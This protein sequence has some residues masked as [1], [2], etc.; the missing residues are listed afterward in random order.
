MGRRLPTLR[1][2]RSP[3]WPFAILAAVYLFLL[4]IFVPWWLDNNLL[5]GDGAGHLFLVEFTAE[6]LLPFGSGWCDRVWGGF[7]VGQLYPPLFHILGG[8]L[9]KLTGPLVA[10]KLLV[11]ITWLTIPF[12]LYLVGGALATA[13]DP[14]RPRPLLHATLIL[15]GWCGLILPSE[16]LGIKESLGTNL[17][18]A[19]G[20]G[21]FPSAAGCAAWLFCTAALLRRGHRRPLAT[22]I[23]LTLTVLLHPVWGLVAA[24]SALVAATSSVLAPPPE[25]RRVRVVQG[26]A[27]TGLL[28]FALSAF[29]A[30]PFLANAGQVHTTHIP[31]QW[32]AA[33]WWLVAAGAGLSALY[34]RFLPPAV[35]VIAM[36]AATLMAFAGLGSATHLA[37][38]FYRLTLPLTLLA[39]TLLSYLLYQPWS[40][41]GGSSEGPLPPGRTVSL[42]RGANFLMLL[43]LTAI[44]HTLG[45]IYPRGNPD[46]Q[47][48]RLEGAPRLQG[49]IAALTEPLHSPGYMSLPWAVMASGGAVSHGISVES[50]RTARPIFGLLRKLS[51]HQFVWGVDM[52]GNPALR[53]PDPDGAITRKQLALLG[54][55]HL[56]AD[57][58]SAADIA[59]TPPSGP[60]ALLFPNFVS[61]SRGDLKALTKTH[62][63]TA[64][65]AALAYHLHPLAE[66]SL[67]N[68]SL[69]YHPVPADR[70]DELCERWFASGGDAPVPTVGLPQPLQP[71]PG[72]IARAT[73]I[74]ASGDSLQVEISGCSAADAP[75]YVK[76]PYHANWQARGENG[77]SQTL[78]PAGYGMLVLADNGTTSLEYTLGPIDWCGRALTLL[79]LLLAV[80]MALAARRSR[81][82]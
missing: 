62:Y 64:D 6:H 22:A 46:L 44:F 24:T 7:V 76:I 72:C 68:F 8:A 5:K 59:T 81:T 45:P 82:R 71:T 38:H 77:D 23:P 32:P 43:A 35:R 36:T 29:F 13:A 1:L 31:L 80:T 66:Q 21:M 17:E 10:I 34:W 79:G 60:P 75:L 52:H 39:L 42:L 12:G 16:I 55:S 3:L 56:L 51:P 78:L 65:G 18:S 67:V 15:A 50:A 11:T 26:W 41:T 27:I 30:L 2:A 25:E 49:R 61:Q 74:A 70:F 48:A 33:L 47:P 69:S 54:F 9:A 28:A 58:K 73:E 57:L 20:N 14:C 37:F 19:I 4:T 53:A 40:T 63:L